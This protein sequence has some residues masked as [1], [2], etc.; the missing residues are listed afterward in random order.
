M[1]LNAKRLKSDHGVNVLSGRDPHILACNYINDSRLRKRKDIS[2]LLEEKI[3]SDISEKLA[4]FS[5][6]SVV[7]CSSEYF[8]LSDKASVLEYFSSYFDEIV[9]IYT[10]RRQDKLLASGF[11]QDV[12]ALERTSNLVWSKNDILMDYYANCQ[13]WKDL[14][15]GIS[16]INFDQVRKSGK[17]LEEIFFKRCGVSSD[18]SDYVSPNSKGTNYSLKNREVLLK[19]AINRRGIDAP[20]LMEE[21]AANNEKDVEFSLPKR[22]EQIVM[23]HYAESNRLFAKHFC[24]VSDM[25]EFYVKDPLAG[26]IDKFE[27]DPLGESESIV[28]FLLD[29]LNYK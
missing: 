15:A 5:S 17:K 27:W 21:F 3:I 20:G 18:F 22:Y 1:N 8:T 2:G 23:K 11:N 9:I 29:K 6:D 28:I 7:I 4:K 24:G 10:V 12:K 14:G 25:Q 26:S 16:I 13:A 19:L